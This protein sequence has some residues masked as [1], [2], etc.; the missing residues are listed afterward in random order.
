MGDVL[1]GVRV[2]L[3]NDGITVAGT[4]KNVTWRLLP[5]E[6]S[7]QALQ[8]DATTRFDETTVTIESSRGMCITIDYERYSYTAILLK[9]GE[10][11]EQDGFQHF[12]LLLTRM[13]GSLKEVLV[14]YLETTFDSRVSSLNLPSQTIT[15]IF[16]KYLSDVCIGED[17]E[18]LDSAERIRALRNIVKETEIFIGFKLASNSGALNSFEIH[19]AREDIP[20]LLTKGKS[21]Q[22]ERPD[23]SPFM[24]AL[25][26]YVQ[27]HLALDLKHEKV[28]ITRIACG[29]FVLGAEGKVKITEPTGGELQHQHFQATQ[30]LIEGLVQLATKNPLTHSDG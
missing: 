13:P 27:G 9:S 17:G 2:G 5:D 29:A 7:W 18:E 15:H 14:E 12:P 8:A 24:L 4:L 11:R 10:E 25:T 28:R 22:H 3:E 16:E 6:E 19:L 30:E 26:T 20:R 1:R 21:L 23:K